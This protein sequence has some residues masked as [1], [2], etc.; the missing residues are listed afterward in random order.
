MSNIQFIVV[1]YLYKYACI[2][3]SFAFVVI[4]L[5]CAKEGRQVGVHSIDKIQKVGYPKEM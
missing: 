5:H 2:K 4:T 3:A 1:Y